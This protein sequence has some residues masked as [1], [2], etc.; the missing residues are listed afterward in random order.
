[1]TA[2]N[3][4]A[5]I[6]LL[7]K[8]SAPV[9]RYTSYP[10][11]PHFT[12]RVGELQYISW[13]DDIADGTRL[14]L[15][16]HIPYCHELC[17]YCGCN[18]KATRRYAPVAQYVRYLETEIANLAVLVPR[19]HSVTH[20]HWGG[21]SPNILTRGDIHSLVGAL[22]SAFKM[23]HGAEFAVEIDPR[24]LEPD[25]IAAI[26]EVGV[27][28]VSV[29]VQDFDETVQAAIGRHQSFAATKAAIDALRS[30]GM[31][32]I[33]ID[34]MYG[35][36]H[37][38]RRSIDRTLE[39]VLEL[40]PDRIA[41]FGYAHLPSRLKHQRLINDTTLPDVVERYAQ[42]RRISRRL[43]ESGYVRIGLD[44]FAKPGDRLANGPVRRNFQGYTTDDASVLLGIGASA[45]GHLPQGYVQNATATHDYIRRIR[46]R[47]LA[48]ARG[49]ELSVDDRIRAY[50]IE[51]LMCDGSFSR[52]DVEC[53][54]G[55]AAGPVLSD[56]ELLIQS[57]RDG[58]MAATADGFTVTEMGRPFI[59]TICACFD[60]H[61]D[62]KAIRYSLG[63]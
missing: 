24:H 59:R 1:M 20:L 28:R 60:T 32:S 6:D 39:R 34:L 54:F 3:M 51:R 63:V 12:S 29:G 19:E 35:L 48:T 62:T 47:G 43:D 31:R 9:P 21:G 53:L 33:N 26:C 14:S 13:L 40:E 30:G 27:T 42:S 10:T 22:H 58:L 36:P 55:S 23:G 37:Q 5:P 56:A 45:I 18:T 50:V 41:A 25:Q 7:R 57:D 38:T 44:H 11:A 46:D 15:Y 8:Y 49:I 16:V 17:W 61:L 2:T 4:R 52:S